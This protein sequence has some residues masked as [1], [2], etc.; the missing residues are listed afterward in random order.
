MSVRRTV[1]HNV[2]LAG[3]GAGVADHVGATVGV[4]GTAVAVASL[5]GTTV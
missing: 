4:G 2:T 3:V 1:V 5:V